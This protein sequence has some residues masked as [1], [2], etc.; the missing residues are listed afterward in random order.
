MKTPH[1]TKTPHELSLETLYLTNL[2]LEADNHARYGTFPPAA[3]AETI[4]AIKDAEPFP[5]AA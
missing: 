4:A 5:T 1:E 3:T 2:G